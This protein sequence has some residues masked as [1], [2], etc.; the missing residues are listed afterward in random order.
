MEA[1]EEGRRRGRALS[2][3]KKEANPHNWVHVRID[4]AWALCNN[5]TLWEG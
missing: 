2:V 1:P 3:E 4:F 5:M